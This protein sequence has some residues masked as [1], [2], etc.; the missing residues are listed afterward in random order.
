VPQVCVI[1]RQ[2]FFSRDAE[3]QKLG[4]NDHIGISLLGLV[5]VL[6][7]EQSFPEVLS[8]TNQRRLVHSLLHIQGYYPEGAFTNM[9]F[10][11][12]YSQHDPLFQKTHRYSV[13][14]RNPHQRSS[15]GNHQAA[16]ITEWLVGIAECF[17]GI[18]VV[19][20]MPAVCI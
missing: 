3:V 12:G 14:T 15:T 5:Q 20:G 18:T 4:R 8:F 13:D 1:L 10:P 16:E 2:R 7:A 19:F 9:S 17:V 6:Y 11:L